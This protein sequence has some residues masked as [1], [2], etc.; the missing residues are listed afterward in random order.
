MGSPE[1][2]QEPFGLVLRAPEECAFSGVEGEAVKGPIS[3]HFKLNLAHGG[4]VTAPSPDV[5]TP[6]RAPP[7]RPRDLSRALVS[8][9]ASEGRTSP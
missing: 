1:M 3:L 8:T 4:G 5:R 2:S 6:R 9:S 7:L